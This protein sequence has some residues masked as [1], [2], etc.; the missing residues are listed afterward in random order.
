LNI[1]SLSTINTTRIATTI[2]KVNTTNH[3]IDILYKIW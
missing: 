1:F 3:I 2:G